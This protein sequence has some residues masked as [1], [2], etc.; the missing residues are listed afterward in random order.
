VRLRANV[1]FAAAAA[2]GTFRLFQLLKNSA[3]VAGGF[4][5]QAVGT[6]VAVVLNGCSDTLDVVPGDFFIVAVQQDTGSAL[7]VVSGADTW[8][9]ME[10]VS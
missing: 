6:T 1:H 7:Q 8:F 2:A 4:N 10:I 3:L 9:A 5:I